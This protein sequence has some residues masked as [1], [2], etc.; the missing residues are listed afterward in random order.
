MMDTAVRRL[1][2]TFAV[3][4]ELPASYHCRD[5]KSD[6]NVV[7]VA[8][9]DGDATR[10]EYWTLCDILQSSATI[11]AILASELDEDA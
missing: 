7:R 4:A 1:P 6:K 8:Q 9:F 2:S 5:K 10:L 11:N 3:A